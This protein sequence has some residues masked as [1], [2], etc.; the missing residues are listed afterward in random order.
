MTAGHHNGDAE[1]L[2]GASSIGDAF[3]DKVREVT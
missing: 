2:V 1:K 3:F